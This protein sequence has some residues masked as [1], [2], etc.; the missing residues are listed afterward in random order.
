MPSL[1]DSTRPS[2]GDVALQRL[3]LL[4]G[5]EPSRTESTV[6][7]ARPSTAEAST[8]GSDCGEVVERWTPV[9]LREARTDPG[10]RARSRWSAVALLAASCCRPPT[11]GTA[12]RGPQAIAPPPVVAGPAPAGRCAPSASATSLVV[13]VSGKVRRPGVVTVPAGARVIDVLKAAGGPLPGADLGTAQPGAQG[14][15]RGARG[16][17]ACPPR[18]RP[19]PAGGEARCRR[20]CGRRS[21]GPIDLNTATLA[22]LDTL[23]GVGPVLAQRILD[24][25]DRA[26]PVRHASISSL[27]SR[28]SATPGWR[29]SATWC[30][31]EPWT[32]RPPP[33]TRDGRRPAGRRRVAAWLTRAS[34]TLVLPLGRRRRLRRRCAARRRVLRLQPAGGAGGHRGAGPRLRRRGGAGDRCP[35]GRASRARRSPARPPAGERHRGPRARRRSATVAVAVRYRRGVADRC[36]VEQVTAGGRTLVAVRSGAG[37]RTGRGLAAVCCRASG[38][39]VDGRLSPPPRRDL[40]VAVLSARSAPAGSPPPGMQTAAGRIRAGLPGRG[41]RAARRAAWA[42]LPGLVRGDTSGL[43][44][45]AGGATSDRRALPSDRGQRSERARS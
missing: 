42:L 12:G 13:A 1:R 27:T 34:P 2:T 26:R 5:S 37:A 33:G 35:R 20:G 14:G 19:G 38:C 17:R 11:S 29:S 7:S 21:A 18:L 25:R 39:R 43:D 6:D 41:G 28:A 22:Q 8:A 9:G 31:S 45:E 3:A 10:R 40:T 4:L 32:A 16:G 36:A 44:P 23:P 15:R 24:W 30:G